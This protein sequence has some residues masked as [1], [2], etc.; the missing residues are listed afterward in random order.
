[1]TD[2]KWNDIEKLLKEFEARLGRKL[3]SAQQDLFE[4]LK[5]SLSEKIKFDS[6]GRI[7]SGQ[8]L[9]SVVDEVFI[10]FNQSGEGKALLQF[11]VE[12]IAT[13]STLNLDYYSPSAPSGINWKKQSADVQSEI[14]K[15]IGLVKT[16]KGFKVIPGGY[17][18]SMVKSPEV[19]KAVKK[20][21]VNA[22]FG[23]KDLRELTKGLKVVVAGAKEV[24][25]VL[26]RHYKTFAYDTLQQANRVEAKKLAEVIGL[27]AAFYAGNV[28][29]STRC[30]CNEHV[31]K[32]WLRSEMQEW[33][34]TIGEKCGVIW[35]DNLP[36]YQPEKDMGGIRCRHQQRWI[37]PARAMQLDDSLKYENGSLKRK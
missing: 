10:K 17:L 29:D 37:T 9:T 26:K 11:L 35:S 31:G 28:I 34:D 2:E 36:E 12:S 4:R 30:F 21:M 16:D 20:E 24:D 6:S 32:V 1:M 14:F 8:D 27:E 5:D 19:L 15:S 23:K 22:V 3:D 13:S 33:S 18:E 7:A 25:G